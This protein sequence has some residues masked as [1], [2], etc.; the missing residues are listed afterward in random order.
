MKAAK[1]LTPVAKGRYTCSVGMLQRHLKVILRFVSKTDAIVFLTR[2]G[3]H[4]LVL[5]SYRYYL[6][7]MNELDSL[8][9][10]IDDVHPTKQ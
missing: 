9:R 4:D 1:G 8:R 6:K 2:H 10:K 5:M 7:S 3:K